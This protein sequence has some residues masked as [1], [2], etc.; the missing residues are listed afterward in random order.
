M[1]DEHTVQIAKK[2]NLNGKNQGTMTDISLKHTPVKRE[3]TPEPIIP[4]LKRDS[5][6]TPR[7]DEL[8]RRSNLSLSNMSSISLD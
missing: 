8:M 2:R 6:P 1:I 3:T 7:V 4:Y 5:S